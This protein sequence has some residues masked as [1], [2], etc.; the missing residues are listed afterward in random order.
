MVVNKFAGVSFSKSVD[1]RCIFVLFIGVVVFVAAPKFSAQP[2]ILKSCFAVRICYFAKLCYHRTQCS[3]RAGTQ[4]KQSDYHSCLLTCESSWCGSIRIMLASP[5]WNY[6]TRYLM[7]ST[8]MNPK[9]IKNYMVFIYAK[10][11]CGFWKKT[12]YT[13]SMINTP[14]RFVS[15][16]NKKLN[17]NL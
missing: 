1:N 5:S 2:Q 10:T 3:P 8:V 6:M 9:R 17:N 13:L 7:N 16:F 4:S 15:Y 11:L 12:L 14:K